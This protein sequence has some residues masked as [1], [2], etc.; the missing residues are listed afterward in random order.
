MK[1]KVLSLV[2]TAMLLW[3]GCQ[4]IIPIDLPP[5]EP[6]LVVHCIFNPD[7]E[8]VASVTLSQALD[9]AGLATPVTNAA[10]QILENG[11]PV[12]T[13]GHDSADFYRAALGIKPQVG[14]SYTIQVSAPDYATVTGNDRIPTPIGANN[15]QWQDSATVDENGQHLSEFKFT[16]NDPPNE[17]NYYMLRVHYVG[18]ETFDQDTTV[19]TGW[20]YMTSHDP[21]VKFYNSMAAAIFDDATFDGQSR[22][23][24]LFV[25]DYWWNII[26]GRFYVLSQVSPTYYHYIQ[27][28]EDYYNVNGNPFAEPVRIFSNMTPGMGVFAG[29]SSFTDSIPR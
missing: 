14:H 29:Y 6:E 26:H 2:L 12:A 11:V 9:V 4:Q 15:L 5:A 22:N 25:P 21:V 20:Y 24:T 13:L 28:F 19:A 23:F 27:T 7:S 8:W 10:V 16:I 1:L 17:K 18:F 3:S